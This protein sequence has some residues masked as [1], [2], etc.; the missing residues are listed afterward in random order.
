MPMKNTFITFSIVLTISLL[1]NE[2]PFLGNQL[3]LMHNSHD[4]EQ[5]EKS[6]GLNHLW[7]LKLTNKNKVQKWGKLLKTNYSS[8]LVKIY[9]ALKSITAC[10]Y[11]PHT[12]DK[13]NGFSFSTKTMWQLS[14]QIQ[15]EMIIFWLRKRHFQK[16]N[17]KPKT[18]LQSRHFWLLFQKPWGICWKPLMK[19]I[20]VSI[21]KH[22]WM[23]KLFK[24]H[25][26][27]IRK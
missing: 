20:V 13:L 24:T 4:M 10:F 16:A 26:T 17:F 21:V 18:F 15:C 6:G 8:S 14:I 1:K 11:F 12:E 23:P 27:L 7:I 9:F 5:G 25:V 3:A 19:F 22:Q 2:P